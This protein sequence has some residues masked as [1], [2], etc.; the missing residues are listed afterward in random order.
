MAQ[1]QQTAAAPKIPVVEPEEVEDTRP[2][3]AGQAKVAFE[4]VRQALYATGL[5]LIDRM[6]N[7]FAAARK[8]AHAVTLTDVLLLSTRDPVRHVMDAILMGKQYVDGTWADGG[9]PLR[10][11]GFQL[12]STVRVCAAC[13]D[14]AC[15]QKG[16]AHYATYPNGPVPTKGG[17]L[18]QGASQ[19]KERFRL[20]LEDRVWVRIDVDPET[21]LLK[22]KVSALEGFKILREWGC[23]VKDRTG[24]GEVDEPA[25]DASAIEAQR[26]EVK[27]VKLVK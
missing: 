26:T 18:E 6:E 20:G 24:R 14:N 21:G 3:S 25:F 8:H 23:W 10:A 17:H 27:P 22:R 16:K 5:G 11:D 2:V 13:A 9:E 4:A 12:R 15:G 7:A 1:P 19:A